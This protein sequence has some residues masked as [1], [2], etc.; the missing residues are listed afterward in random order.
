MDDVCT[1][2]IHAARHNPSLYHHA[3]IVALEHRSTTSLGNSGQVIPVLS[4]H[5]PGPPIRHTD[6][7]GNSSRTL[8]TAVGRLDELGRHG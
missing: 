7:L 4:E 2:V 6:E 8:W 1:A 3:A 5:I